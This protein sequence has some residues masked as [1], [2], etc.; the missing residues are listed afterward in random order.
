MK[1]P[2]THELALQLPRWSQALG[3][4]VERVAHLFSSESPYEVSVPTVLTRQRHRDAARRRVESEGLRGSDSLSGRGPNL[5]GMVSE[6]KARQKPRNSA[7]KPAG[8]RCKQCG[9]EVP[10]SFERV[11]ARASYCPNC[12]STRR[13][14]I[15]RMIQSLPKRP[16]VVSKESSVKRSLENAGERALRKQF[17]DEHSGEEW[18]PSVFQADIL[19]S[20]QNLSLT[21]IAR[22][23]GVSTST[24]SKIRSGQGVPHP[25]H[26]EGLE[27]VGTTG[28]A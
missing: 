14:E 27:R 23:I 28:R 12:L 5:G 11:T 16:R 17:D 2:L 18:D 19:P 4:I 9:G 6:R 26:W 20:L 7:P 10:A 1:A 15:G 24:A 3:P 25:R 22:A 8:A 21:T 13:Q